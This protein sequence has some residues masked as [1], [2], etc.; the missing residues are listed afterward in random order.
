MIEGKDKLNK[1]FKALRKQ[2][3]IARQ[4]FSCCGGCA[5]SEIGQ[6]LKK[7]ENQAKRGG[8]YYHRQDADRLVDGYVY[9]GYGARVDDPSEKDREVGMIILACAAEAG[10]AVIW[11]GSP[12]Q[13]LRIILNKEGLPQ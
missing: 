5:S 3:L 2:N 8:V 7:P 12:R 6:D 10:L 1:M 9:L 4:R 11:N 13:R